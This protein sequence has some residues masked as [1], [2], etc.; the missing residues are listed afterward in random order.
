MTSQRDFV[1]EVI[2]PVLKQAEASVTVARV[3]DDIF[4]GPKK[5]LYKPPFARGVYGGQVIGQA[6]MAAANTVPP[7]V[8]IHSFHCYFILGGNPD[9]DIVYTVKR[10]RDGKAFF[11]RSVVARQGGTPIFTMAAQFHVPEPS[12]GLRYH[13]PIPEGITRPEDLLDI[14]EYWAAIQ[15]HP[16]L[17]ANLKDYIQRAQ[18]R[19]VTTDQRIVHRSFL[20]HTDKHRADLIPHLWPLMIGDGKPLRYIWM[21]SHS[22]L[23]GG[24]NIHKC[25]IAFMSDMAFIPTAMEPL[26]SNDH[27]KKSPRIAMTVSL[28]HSM[29]FHSDIAELRADQWLLFEM[30]CH[31]TGGGRALLTG[32]VWSQAG[33]LVV[34]VTQEA[35]IR[36]QDDNANSKL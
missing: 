1:P 15:E 13:E 5:L 21:K 23:D 14:Y 12:R 35:L 34:T 18:N 29:W 10:L 9:R 8:P 30:R 32:K 26:Y 4:I 33:E 28:D 22:P 7:S 25:V 17:H 36:L 20:R 16:R 27:T 24:P 2:P 6:L 19:P 31:V 3:D 11:T